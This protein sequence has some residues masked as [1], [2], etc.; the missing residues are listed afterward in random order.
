MQT[1]ASKLVL[2]GTNVKRIFVDGGFSKNPIY[3][4]LLAS[5]FPEMEVFAASVAQATSIG[6]ALA[7]H[8]HWNSKSLATNIIDLNFYSASE[9]V[10]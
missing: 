5:A 2:E 3:M 10:L 9:L 6:A 7:I 4:Q 8:K 1:Q